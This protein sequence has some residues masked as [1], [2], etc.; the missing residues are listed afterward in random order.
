MYLELAKKQGWR[1]IDIMMKISNLSLRLLLAGAVVVLPL[2]AGDEGMPSS[3]VRGRKAR[4]EARES[5]GKVSKKRNKNPEERG[6][7]ESN[8]NDWKIADC[9]AWEKM[10]SIKL[11]QVKIQDVKAT[12]FAAFLTQKLKDNKQS[13]VVKYHP[14]SSQVAEPVVASLRQ[15][16]VSLSDLL[17]QA[18]AQMRCIYTVEN[19]EVGIYSSRHLFTRTYSVKFEELRDPENENN[20]LKVLMR[21]L[22]LSMPAGAD[23]SFNEA[24]DKLTLVSN[25]GAHDML[26][27]ILKQLDE[28]RAALPKA[29]RVFKRYFS[30][31]RKVSKA[32]LRVKADGGKSTEKKLLQ[33]E[34]QL[35]KACSEE[36]AEL[37]AYYLSVNPDELKKLEKFVADLQQP[38]N[39]LI[40]AINAADEDSNAA[41]VA[42]ELYAEMAG[43]VDR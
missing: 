30:T 13:V 33:L 43:F 10:M 15:E 18:C 8:A 37:L 3:S 1:N 36:D 12:D 21:N 23:V 34:R 7:T 31:L 24:G 32:A 38:F 27:K 17:R 42:D 35:Q 40:E 4:V 20:D 6:A 29:A 39:D 22:G 11:P 14:E 5:G 2:A 9:A 28:R 41:N 25:A 26:C 19:G 16:K